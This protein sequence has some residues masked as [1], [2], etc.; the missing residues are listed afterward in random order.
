MVVGKSGLNY[1]HR[2]KSRW[3]NS[4]SLSWLLTNRRLL[5][6]ATAIYFH[7]VAQKQYIKVE[8]VFFLNCVVFFVMTKWVKRNQ[9]ID[10]GS[11]ILGILDQTFLQNFSI[12]QR[13]TQRLKGTLTPCF[14]F[15]VFVVGQK[16]L[17][18]CHALGW[19]QARYMQV[20]EP[21]RDDEPSIFWREGAATVGVMK[22]SHDF[23]KLSW[24]FRR[25]LCM[26]PFPRLQLCVPYTIFEKK[27]RSPP[28]IWYLYDIYIYTYIVFQG[29]LGLTHSGLKLQPWVFRLEISIDS[30]IHSFHHPKSW[31]IHEWRYFCRFNEDG[32]WTNLPATNTP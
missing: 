13:K 18:S 32:I 25:I 1:I 9:Q 8:D 24:G 3:R 11:Q 17:S 22:L 16:D 31:K 19:Q 23:V 12:L 29:G 26:G 14:F 10:D 2:S 20:L 27:K 21:G 30:L 5:G 7:Y 28:H 6:V 15:G 4:H